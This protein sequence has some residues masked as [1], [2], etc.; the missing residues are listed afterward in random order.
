MMDQRIARITESEAEVL[1]A[2][3]TCGHELTMNEL[4]T[5]LAASCDWNRST[6]K[7]M[8]RRLIEKDVITCMQR[9]V[10]Y[11]QP[12]VTEQQ[13]RDFQTGKLIEQVYHGKASK[14]IASLYENQR[15]DPDDIK[16]LRKLLKNGDRHD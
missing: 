12:S 16:E 1:K 13:Y 3:W 14:L 5:L 8:V 9:E 7:T 11:F 4:V 10:Q 2:F 15:L 6:I